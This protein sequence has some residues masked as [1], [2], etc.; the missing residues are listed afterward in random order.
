MSLGCKV[1]V[2]TFVVLF[3]CDGKEFKELNEEHDDH[4]NYTSQFPCGEPQPRA[5][6][7]EEILSK[8]DLMKYKKQIP[9][10]RPLY[11]ILHRCEGSGGCTK[12]GE[13]CTV[14]ETEK[15]KLVYYLGSSG[16][17]KTFEVENHKSCKCDDC[18]NDSRIK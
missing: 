2:V 14:N 3:F 12:Y 6:Y 13:R 17:L 18:N 15:V 11:T 8:D 5:L 1:I 7:L 16:Y 9:K 10:I 4:V